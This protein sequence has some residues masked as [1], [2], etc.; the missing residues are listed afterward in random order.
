MPG[1]RASAS[2]SIAL[3]SFA[4]SSCP[5]TNATA[6]ASSRWVTGIPAY[7]GA[8]TPEVTPGTTSKATPA[9]DSASASSPPLPKTNGSPPF[10]RTTLLPSFAFA[11]RSSSISL[12][13][14]AASPGRLPT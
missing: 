14:M 11:T 9:A 4:G 1:N 5:V 6:P 8:A 12:W 10:R 2:Q 7:A 3:S 13:G